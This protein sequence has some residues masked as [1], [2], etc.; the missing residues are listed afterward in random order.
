MKPRRRYFVTVCTGLAALFVA[1]ATCHYLA[2]RM[3]RNRL[4][5]RLAALEDSV[6][7][8]QKRSAESVKVAESN[9]PQRGE[10]VEG[11]RP[12][13]AVRPR[14]LGSGRAGAWRYLDYS[15][16]DGESRRYYCR[17]NA[18]PR[19]VRRL[20]AS[21]VEDARDHATPIYENAL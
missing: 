20:V 16:P 2:G 18:T 19:E 1:G 17:T 6:A 14:Y 15:Y 8:M 4:L 7:S 5:D 12:T 13:S 10:P 21:L 11:Y 9:E 3:S